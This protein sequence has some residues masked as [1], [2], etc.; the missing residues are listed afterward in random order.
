[1]NLIIVEVNQLKEKLEVL[2]LEEKD[3][4]EKI[5]MEFDLN[6]KDL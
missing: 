4:M 6:K 1:M 5:D 2:D 3:K